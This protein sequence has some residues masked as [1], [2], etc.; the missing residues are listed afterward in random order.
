MI[1]IFWVMFI[2]SCVMS[3]V[4]IDY[5]HKVHN[6]RDMRFISYNLP[7]LARAAENAPDDMRE[8]ISFNIH[9]MLLQI[10]MV[11]NNIG[12]FTLSVLFFNLNSLIM[13]FV[14]YRKKKKFL[15]VMSFITIVFIYFTFTFSQEA[16]KTFPKKV[17][18]SFYLDEDI[19]EKIE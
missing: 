9:S 1:T 18:G 16:M 6:R 5:V 8:F 17:M 4:L 12:L 10:K 11:R 14:A 13:M 15:Y 19:F 2:F 3:V 7:L